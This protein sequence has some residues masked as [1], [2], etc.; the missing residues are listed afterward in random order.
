M[1]NICQVVLNSEHENKKIKNFFSS[2]NC[3][4][5]I[6]PFA[7]TLKILGLNWPGRPYWD[8][9]LYISYFWPLVRSCKFQLIIFFHWYPKIGHCAFF[10]IF[11]FFLYLE[12]Q[13]KNA[14]PGRETHF[15][16]LQVKDKVINKFLY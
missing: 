10:W 1:S 9:I 12:K 13:N 4:F 16:P 14:N 11:A 15:W 2:H 8:E 5:W 6:R 3:L 7:A